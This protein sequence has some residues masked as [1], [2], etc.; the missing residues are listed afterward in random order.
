MADRGHFRRV[1][2]GCGLVVGATVST[3]GKQ[4]QNE[5]HSLWERLARS[6]KSTFQYLVASQ[7]PQ[8][9]QRIRIELDAARTGLG[10]LMMTPITR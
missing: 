7:F 8:I 1:W 4:P 9:R 2:V 10:A 5:M 6:H 3:T